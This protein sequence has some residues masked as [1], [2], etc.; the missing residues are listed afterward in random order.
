MIQAL[1]NLS[2]IGGLLVIFVIGPWRP[3]YDRYPEPAG[4]ADVSAE[5][6]D[7]MRTMT[8]LAFAAP[9]LIAL[10]APA[11]EAAAQSYIYST[12]YC[13]RAYDGAMDCSYFTLAAMPGRR[14]PQ[15][16]AIAPSIRAMPASR[17]R[18]IAERLGSSAD[19]SDA[20]IA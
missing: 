6:F 15:P 16:A 3:G 13:S 7:A 11:S 18:V 20:M 5:E 9:A 8:A 12:Q 19:A 14:S 1:K 4:R 17:R 2:L 10:T